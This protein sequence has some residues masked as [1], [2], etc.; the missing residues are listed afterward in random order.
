[1]NGGRIITRQRQRVGIDQQ[2]NFSAAEND[3]IDTEC[4]GPGTGFVEGYWALGANTQFNVSASS[5]GWY[6]LSLRYSNGFAD[7]NI[8]VYVNGNKLG[9]SALPIGLA[10]LVMLPLL[11]S[12]MRLPLA[13]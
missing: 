3:G 11:W 5:A 9:Q 2:R 13:V 4:T 1:M 12:S 7:S 8:S 6:D 10:S